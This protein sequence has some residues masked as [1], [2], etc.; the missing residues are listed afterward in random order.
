MRS[1]HHV[2]RTQS[3]RYHINSLNTSIVERF[4]FTREVPWLVLCPWTPAAWEGKL[5]SCSESSSGWSALRQL[6]S[7]L[8]AC[9]GCGVEGDCVPLVCVPLYLP[10]TQFQTCLAVWYLFTSSLSAELYQSCTSLNTESK[11]LPFSF[12]SFWCSS[13]FLL[14]LFSYR[15]ATPDR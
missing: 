13:T 2:K 4:H 12:F 7:S 14:C 1:I 6:F 8:C 11:V 10:R 3:K 15:F 9:L 5:G